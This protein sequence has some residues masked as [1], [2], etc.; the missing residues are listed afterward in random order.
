MLTDTEAASKAELTCKL[1]SVA[2]GKAKVTVAGNVE[3][4]TA[5]SSAKVV[6][7]GW[8]LFDLKA[9][10]L[11]EAQLQQT[12][13]RTVGPVS[14]GIKVTA[15]ASMTR[16]PTADKSDLSDEAA[17]AIPLSPPAPLT[18]LYFRAPW[19]VEFRHDRAWHVFQ[20][21][22]E[23]AVLRLMDHGTFIA[24]CNLAQFV[25]PTGASMLPS[26]N[27]RATFARAW[28]RGSKQSR[29]RKRSR[30]TIIASCIA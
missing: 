9:E 29:R 16:T 3:G 15:T 30:R 18:E 27:F 24:Q 19:N 11:V 6:L 17:A 13:E 1:E 2:D 14:P 22:L 12:E 4:A 10:R 5:G 7:K 26:I 20:Q 23:I 8:Y 25:R 21:S 28:A